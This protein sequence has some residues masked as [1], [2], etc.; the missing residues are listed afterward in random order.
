MGNNVL[1][2]YISE[3]CIC[4]NFVALLFEKFGN[5]EVEDLYRDLLSDK[6]HYSF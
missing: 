1:Y 5:L 6:R 4:Y 2:Y 3:M